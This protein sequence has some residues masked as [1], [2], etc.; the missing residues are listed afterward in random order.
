M[1]TDKFNVQ[2]VLQS[3]LIIIHIINILWA[4]HTIIMQ[5]ARILKNI[6]DVEI[7]WWEYGTEILKVFTIQDILQRFDIKN[8]A[9]DDH[10]LYIP[11]VRS[12]IITTLK[13]FFAPIDRYMWHK[14]HVY[15]ISISCEQKASS[16]F[17]LY[18]MA[19]MHV[20]AT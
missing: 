11:V 7:F 12:K 17:K 4:I 2:L 20:S 16:D 9:C 10:P 14:F 15:C 3:E 13:G 5:T 19:P 6:S 8:I 1:L 18:K